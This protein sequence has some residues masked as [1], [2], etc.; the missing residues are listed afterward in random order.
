M[1]ALSS[2]RP[3]A[4][5]WS[6]LAHRALR[7][8]GHRVGAARERVIVT[9]ARTGR[10]TAKELA[11]RL[12]SGPERI[13]VSSVYRSLAALVDAQALRTVELAGVVHYELVGLTEGGGRY[14][15]C[16]CCGRTANFA[17]P[18][19]DAAIAQA[20]AAL[21]YAVWDEDVVVHGRCSTCAEEEPE[22]RMPL[23]SL[24][25]VADD[26]EPILRR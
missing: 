12:A 26:H 13:A 9:I 14:L 11:A 19:A 8:H 5:A 7:Q 3:E 6:E 23:G 22:V 10:V 16:R 17:S 1:E 2:E 15:V 24:A 25:L 18:E 4:A 21:G 20:A